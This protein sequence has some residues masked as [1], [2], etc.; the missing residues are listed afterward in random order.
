VDPFLLLVVV[1]TVTTKVLTVME[2][3]RQQHP[4]ARLVSIGHAD[5]DGNTIRR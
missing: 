5:R 1:I 4:V 2:Y 3:D